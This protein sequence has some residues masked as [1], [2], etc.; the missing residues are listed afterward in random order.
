MRV[1]ETVL[2]V[3]EMDVG[4]NNIPVARDIS[5]V[6]R[7]GDRL[8]IIGPNGTGKST[9]IRTILGELLPLKGITGGVRMSG[10]NIMI[11]SFPVLI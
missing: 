11:R 10:S 2:H 3:E 7:R 6:L 1:S 4:Y 9:F 8:G 5:F